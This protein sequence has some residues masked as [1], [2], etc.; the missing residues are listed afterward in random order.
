MSYVF[1]NVHTS[2][3]LIINLCFNVKCNSMPFFVILSLKVLNKI[4]EFYYIHLNIHII[5]N[6]INYI[7][8]YVSS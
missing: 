5:E 6:V 3:I 1:V 7:N 4:F 2:Q 8:R